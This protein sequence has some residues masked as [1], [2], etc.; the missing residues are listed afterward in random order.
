MGIELA[1]TRDRVSSVFPIILHRH[2]SCQ[3]FENSNFVSYSSK[4]K[5]TVY[6]KRYKYYKSNISP[7]EKKFLQWGSNPRPHDFQFIAL[8]TAPRPPRSSE[9][10]ICYKY[11]KCMKKSYLMYDHK[12]CVPMFS[13][14]YS[15]SLERFL[16][17]Q[18][19]SLST[20]QNLL[21]IK[22]HL[23]CRHF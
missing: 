4:N 5:Q 19:A 22:S 13:L 11:C 16:Q 3:R 10:K 23:C 8:S 20:I 18:L 12:S 1:E 17:I 15:P 21:C 14:L 9:F 7:K 2:R 6:I